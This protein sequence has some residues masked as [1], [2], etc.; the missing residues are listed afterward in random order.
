MK[1]DED[2]QLVLT[3]KKPTEWERHHRRCQ[4]VLRA[5]IWLVLNGYGRL[6]VLPYDAPSGCYWR[7][8]L[9]VAGD[10]SRELFRY[11]SASKGQ[12]L[13]DHSGVK[14]RANIPVEKLAHLIVSAAPRQLLAE[15]EGEASFETMLW[16][17]EL[18]RQLDNGG[19]PYAFGDYADPGKGLWYVNYLNGYSSK[20][21]APPDYLSPG[22]EPE[23]CE[24]DLS[25]ELQLCNAKD[26]L[27]QALNRIECL[28]SEKADIERRMIDLQAQ[29]SQ[30]NI[31]IKKLQ[32]QLD[33]VAVDRAATER[34]RA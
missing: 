28:K 32:D 23:S 21:K 8:S 25:I 26:D 11:S 34:R 2:R 31:E 30:A 1:N 3:A 7:L 17:L 5:G 13:A 19:L 33:M 15:C 24:R 12:Y 4:R 20:M 9:H 14:T 18:E 6:R 16:L 29:V 22:E 10:M 27:F